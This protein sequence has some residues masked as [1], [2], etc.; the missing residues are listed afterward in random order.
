[1]KNH[2]IFPYVGNKRQE[3][4]FLNT[5]GF[6]NLIE[7]VDI[8]I[9]AFCGSCAFAFQFWYF[10]ERG[11][12]D[13]KYKYILNDNNNLL[14]ELLTILKSP[15]DTEKLL[16]DI[17][18]YLK[19]IDKE[20]YLAIR[21]NKNIN[22]IEYVILNSCYNQRVGIYDEKSTYKAHLI[23]NKI[24][25]APIINFL[26]EA[27]ITITNTNGETVYDAHK[28]NKNCLIYCDPP[29]LNSCNAYY[30]DTNMNIY[31]YIFNDNLKNYEAIILFHLEDTFLTKLLTQNSLFLIS[32][33]DKVYEMTKI[34]TSHILLS[35]QLFETT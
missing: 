7:N 30:R 23:I 35:N 5:F 24:R 28:N 22:I 33:Y 1:M 25:N 18:L 8:I 2:F 15:E 20:K 6:A 16:S 10:Y 34:K 9:D 14:T 31:E 4:K 32:K 19:T 17:E 21:K 3:L 27:D 12:D 26:R 29:Y 11:R 13:K